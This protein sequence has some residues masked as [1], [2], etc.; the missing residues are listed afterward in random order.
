MLKIENTVFVLIDVQGKLAQVMHEKDALFDN[1]QKL[2]SGIKALKIP[3]IWIEQIPEKMGPTIPELSELL[4]NEKPI[5]KRCFSCCHD[6][7][8]MKRLNELA[9]K[10]ILIAGIETHV[11]VYQTAVM[12]VEMGYEAEV[13]ADGTS[14][15][16]LS[17]K[18]TGL[19]RIRLAGA[20]ITSVEMA[21]FELLKT[22]DHSAF[23]EILKIVK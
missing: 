17:N 3:I 2:V 23:R 9:R 15:R 21:L 22:A 10:Q 1:L 11:C 7:I 8:F 19:E 16:A 6:S 12:L 4:K 18:I 14:S 13:A 5:A 20:R